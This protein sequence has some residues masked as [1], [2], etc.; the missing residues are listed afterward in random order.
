VPRALSA[1]IIATGH[2]RAPLE[3][4]S[5]GERIGW[6]DDVY[7]EGPCSPNLIA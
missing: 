6:N 7:S 4:L 3:G 5:I 2:T 1:D